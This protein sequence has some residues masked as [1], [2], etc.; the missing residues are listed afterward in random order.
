[1]IEA[2]EQV[3]ALIPG[4]KLEVSHNYAEIRYGNILLFSTRGPMCE[5]SITPYL[6]GMITAHKILTT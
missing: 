3:K 2:Y 4:I 1:M 5:S 6:H